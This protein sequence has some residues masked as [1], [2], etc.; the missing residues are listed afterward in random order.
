I[1]QAA[2]GGRL[3]E[4]SG[5][6][7]TAKADSLATQ[8]RLVLGEEAMVSR[9]TARGQLRLF[10]L[11]DSVTL[12]EVK[13]VISEGGGCPVSEVRI[14]HIRRTAKGIGSVWVQCPLAAAMKLAG[15]GRVKVGWVSARVKLLKAKPVQC[16]KCWQFGHVRD[17]CRATVERSQ[18]CYNCGRPGHVAREC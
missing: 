12:E 14:G 10:G 1:R 6:E 15:F 3:L 18:A 16:Y 13:E 9:P 17:A 7:G 5:P 4:I 11:D 8:L 2:N